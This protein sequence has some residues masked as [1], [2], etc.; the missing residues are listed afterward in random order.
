MYQIVY[1]ILTNDDTNQAYI[2]PL[3]IG[4]LHGLFEKKQFKTVDN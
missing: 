3:T 2:C 1:L 4:Q